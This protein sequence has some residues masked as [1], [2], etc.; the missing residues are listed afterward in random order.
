MVCYNYVFA[1]VRVRDFHCFGSVEMIVRFLGGESQVVVLFRD[2]IE[3]RRFRVFAWRCNFIVKLE[4]EYNS[5]VIA[6]LQKSRFRIRCHQSK[7]GYRS[8]LE[9]S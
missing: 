1:R 7:T 6:V 3:I 9:I 5:K 2:F 8:S 4:R